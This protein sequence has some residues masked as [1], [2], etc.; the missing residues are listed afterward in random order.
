M[1]DDVERD[2][3]SL[4]DAAAREANARR[5]AFAIARVTSAAELLALNA[6]RSAR[7]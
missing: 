3:A 5:L 7:T 6:Q 2:V 1:A 4:T